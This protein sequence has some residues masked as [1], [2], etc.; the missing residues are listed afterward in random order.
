M[1]LIV[2][3]GNPGRIYANS[4]HNIGS[5]VV[6]NLSQVYKIP[7]KRNQ[8]T[9]S[10]DGRGRLEGCDVVLAVPL[11]F[12]NLS[13]SA[14]SLLLKK[15]KIGLPRSG[16]KKRGVDGLLIVCDDLDLE[17][18]RIKIKA[19]GSSGGQRGLK[20]IIDSL[21]TQAFCRLRIGI[22][23]PATTND[24]D[25]AE[26]VL[27]PFTKKEKE[28]LKEITQR[29]IS[30]CRTWITEGIFQTMNIFNKRSG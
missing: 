15:H 9:F 23:R 29:A 5:L 20:S 27:S 19:S 28:Q 12:M 2:G 13:G 25:A 21:G 22:G 11:T 18:G 16:A 17:F 24:A 26:Y 14:I 7:L 4:R 30:C 10:L 3:L 1:K 8:A 6:K